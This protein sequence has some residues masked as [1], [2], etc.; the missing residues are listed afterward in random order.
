M[1]V[2]S[3]VEAASR[4]TG[5]IDIDIQTQPC[6]VDLTLRSISRYKG[7]GQLG[8]DNKDRVLPEVREIPFDS[9]GF[10]YLPYDCYLMVFNEVV[11]VPA[12]AMGHAYPRSSLFRIGATFVSAVW[13][14]GYKGR[15]QAMLQVVNQYG[16]SLKKDARVAQLV[17]FRLEKPS[18]TLYNGV[19]QGVM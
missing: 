12:D 9:D 19:Y 7:S 3:G 13:D 1:G 18:K 6:G 14:P 17:F 4:I 5:A 15:G 11:E 2:L 10:A 8:F 16:I